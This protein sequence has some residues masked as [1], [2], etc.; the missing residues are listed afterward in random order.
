MKRVGS[1]GLALCLILLATT[2]QPTAA[3]TFPGTVKKL[4]IPSPEKDY[5]M[6]NVVVWTPPVP[7][8]QVANLP[9]VYLLHGWPGTPSGMMYGA[10]DALNDAFTNGAKPFIAVFPDGNALTHIDSEWADSYDKKA[11]V[12]TWL[13]TNV[14]KTVEAGNIRTRENRAI[15]GFSMGGYGAGII[16]LHHPDLYSQ[17]VTL[18][19]YFVV[20][21]LTNAYGYKPTNAKKVAYQTDSNFLKVSPK[22]RWYMAEATQDTTALIFKQAELW[23]N[24][25]KPYGTDYTI[26]KYDG[27][28]NYAFVA[29]EMAPVA[30]W[31]KWGNS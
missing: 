20:D 26:A 11:M 27:G 15:L 29:A 22:M 14:I 3:Q 13:T 12:E 17:V 9:V 6:R 1:I 2:F 31:F 18:A 10:I 21:D 8:D 4:S 25:M 23:G 28:H 7:D 30:N 24:R 16:A 5:P 19:G